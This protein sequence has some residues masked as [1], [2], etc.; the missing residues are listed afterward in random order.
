M[1]FVLAQIAPELG[2]IDKNL[3][4]ILEII[5][6]A[7]KNNVDLVIFP[8]H[9]L[10]GAKPLSL[11]SFQSFRD[12]V[13]DALSVI[14][15]ETRDI[16]VIIGGYSGDFLFEDNII[17][18]ENCNQQ[19]KN[20]CL[21]FSLKNESF[22]AIIGKKHPN[23]DKISIDI[24]AKHFCYDALNDE[25]GANILRTNLAGVSEN[26]V[27]EGASFIKINNKKVLQ[28]KSFREDILA[29]DTASPCNYS[30]KKISMEEKIILA[31]KLALKNYCEKLGFNKVVLGLS[32]GIDSAI[33]AY[34]ATEVLGA[35]NVVGITMPSEF[36]SKGS[37]SDSEKLAENLGIKIENISIAPLVESYKRTLG[38]VISGIVQE[39]IQARIRGDILMS[40]SNRY[41]HL[42]LST[43]NKS[44]SAV[45][46]CTLYGDMCGGLN[47]IS[48]LPKTLVWQVA[49]Y[50]NK[51]K[52]IIPW[53]IINK[54]PSAE[55]RHNQKDQDSLP[56]YEVLDDIINDFIKEKKSVSTI[57][58]KYSKELVQDV[59]KKIKNAEY[60]RYQATLGVVL[61]CEPFELNALPI[62]QKFS[63]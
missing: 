63:F 41:G 26:L 35:Q 24:T 21:D 46:Y 30:I 14:K 62:T 58:K 45:G 37:V 2:E 36:S 47:L 28:A 15:S 56:D 50:I 11:I 16:A 25:S 8:Q 13:N 55:L 23:L 17:L 12:K 40:Y 48:D 42:L 10:Y 53:A 27:F 31:I 4:K 5:Q 3:K 38:D 51:E 19:N 61:S 52:E 39:N 43:G 20:N 33:S 60:K 57:E 22:S 54:A 9:S 34:F 49:R 6:N 59:F 1:K 32:G 18:F 29:Y 7:K 44:E